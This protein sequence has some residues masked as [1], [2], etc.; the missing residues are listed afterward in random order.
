M[1]NAHCKGKRPWVNALVFLLFLAALAL[2]TIDTIFG[3]SSPNVLTEKRLLNR[4]PVIDG[5]L[6]SARSFPARFEKYYNDNF[7]FRQELVYLN[8]LLL[9]ELLDTSPS[10]QVVLGKEHWLFY[11]GENAIEQFPAL[12]MLS[13][14][15]L[16]LRLRLLNAKGDWLAA[17]G[18]AY[19]FVVAPEKHTIYPE[20]LPPLYRIKQASVTDQILNY[21]R[22]Y[23][24][25]PVI[26]LRTPLW[27]VKAPLP[28]YY[29]SDTHWNSYGAYVGYA[30]I[31][32]TLVKI[33]PNLQPVPM[34]D[35]YIKEHKSGGGDLAAM[36][37]LPK[38][39]PDSSIN[40][41]PRALRR[42]T[43][44]NLGY[45]VN[46]RYEVEVT[47]RA[48]QN[49]P[50]AVMFHDSFGEALKAFLS[51]H[52]ARIVYV[53]GPV[54]GKFD[55]GI[56]E[57]EHPGVVIEEIVGRYLHPLLLPPAEVLDEYARKNNIM[58]QMTP[59]GQ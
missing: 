9:V 48:G 47:K 6:E 3:I 22:L 59:G 29:R 45:Q 17:R 7:G 21:L 25:Y 8:N 26:D 12:K 5:S 4:M 52:F 43:D 10:D 53:G 37:A 15:E 51:E 36:L 57:R 1:E 14:E 30:E 44:V 28:L 50:S 58:F 33:F 56:I 13:P 38:R 46:G 16:D 55:T 19:I 39:Y 24:K 32:K 42:A 35:F 27:K 31:M 34:R 11:S 23:A 2:P 18:I 40:F 54:I 41:T 49:L 20:L